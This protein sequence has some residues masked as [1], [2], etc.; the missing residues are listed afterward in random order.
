[1]N[2]PFFLDRVAPG[3][4]ADA[5]DWD[6]AVVGG[7]TA[8]AVMASRLTED[9][10]TRV[11]LLEAGRD[12]APGR[13]PRDIASVFP[14]ATFNTR[15]VWPDLRAHWRG[16]TTSPALSFQQ[17]RI[18]GGSGSVMGM[19]ALRGVPEDYDGWAA[20]GATGWGWADVLPFFRRLE[21][22]CD[23]AGPLHGADGPIP[24]RR[25]KRQDWSPLAAAVHAAV[26]R[27]GFV[28][29]GDMNADFRDGHCA[30]PISRYA[31]SRASAAICYLTEEVRRRPNL[32]IVTDTTVT[33]LVHEGRHVRGVEVR[34][35]NGRQSTYA[36]AETILAAGALHTPTLLM[37]SG[38]GPAAHLAEMEI[39]V[40]ADRPG[41]GRNLQNHPLMPALAIMPGDRTERALD[42]PP[43]GTY[44]RWSSGIPGGT[45]RDMGLYIRGYLVWHALGRRLAMLAPVLM[46]PRSTGWVR[47]SAPISDA[48]PLVAFNFLDDVRDLKR[49]MAGLRL[50]A[51]IFAAPEL[52]EMC[53]EAFVL[54]EAGRLGKYNNLSRRNA[55]AGWL[56]A[57]VFDVS[58]RAGMRVLNMLARTRQLRD[59]VDDDEALAEFIFGN[60]IGTNHASGTCRIGKP[61]DPMAV[62]DPAGAVYGVSGLR[63]ADASVMPSVPSGNTH[64]PTV[65]V[66]EKIAHAIR[67]GAGRFSRQR[68]R[69]ATMPDEAIAQR[70]ET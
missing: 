24:I 35:S 16:E 47:L 34:H 22:D 54:T 48:T 7:G 39:A 32:R 28:E 19:W 13:P 9:R 25:Q 45:P 23:F 15:Y 29:V 40:V 6:Y 62:V 53:G 18:L 61:D 41:V 2:R 43:A 63:V 57:K 60:I 59:F 69:S 27:L 66:A 36:A 1:M 38:I 56:G 21:T 52:Q 70:N 10:S 64:I 46:K 58:P 31:D 67:T 51:R 26:G 11:V 5:R 68:R 55:V 17:G 30:L 44:L 14:L 20:S 42:R 49:V 50:A 33:R 3:R 37:R 12:L 4:A 8:G 65:M